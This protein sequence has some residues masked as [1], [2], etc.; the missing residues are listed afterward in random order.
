MEKKV[1]A[2]VIIIAMLAG[3]ALNPQLL[4]DATG[5][6]TRPI[7]QS[8][9]KQTIKIGVIASD[10]SALET[11]APFFQKIIQPDIN[12]YCDKLGYYVNFEFIVKDAKGS[13]DTHLK[14]VKDFHKK[15]IDLLI[16]GGWSSQAQGSLAYVNANGM[17]L[18]SS[19][20]T[21]PTL[22]IAGDNLFR[23]CPA[24]NSLAPALVEMM[25]SYGIKSVVIIQRGDS[26]GDGIV[27]LFS[28]QWQS[29]GGVLA[30][31][32]VRYD[33]EA[34]DFTSYLNEAEGQVTT[35]EGLYPGRVGILFLAFNEAAPILQQVAANYP[36][37][38]S[39]VWFGGDG[40]ARSQLI[41][42]EAGEQG[43]HVKLYSLLATNPT[44]S[45]FNDLAARYQALTGQEM[46][47]YT[48]YQ[49]DTA[50]ALAKAVLETQS[51]KG[52][53]VKPLIP[54]I[55]YDMYGAGGWCRL[56]EFGD[57][58]PIP[59]DIWGFTW[60]GAKGYSVLF[61]N[62]NTD[63]NVVAWNIAVPGP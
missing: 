25:W 21:S 19:S 41:M 60:D 18:F 26:W 4:A 35:A 49:Y 13:A 54:Q 9:N 46:G 62:Y 24:D 58:F 2:L 40:T 44:T 7:T 28:P 37:L 38:Y 5:R 59:Y 53:L 23:M 6:I 14:L 29:K 56:N 27:N 32:V 61:G 15:G 31:N 11:A 1:I 55:C 45:K 30:G 42:D 10:T 43:A 3:F 63:L 50:W 47:A 39:T 33:P 52:T 16:G 36:N 12:N 22:A 51:A 57:R 20:S 17:I 8:L 34:T 48:A